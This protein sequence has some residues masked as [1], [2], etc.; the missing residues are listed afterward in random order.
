MPKYAFQDSF[1]FAP[2]AFLDRADY[3]PTNLDGT[4]GTGTW[5]CPSGYGSFVITPAHRARVNETGNAR[6]AFASGV[7]ISTE[8]GVK[9]RV[10][11][12]S[13]PADNN[14][15]FHLISHWDGTYDGA[16]SFVGACYLFGI[17][18]GSGSDVVAVALGFK[19]GLVGD[20]F[21]SLAVPGA[22]VGDAFDLEI[23]T[24]KAG[25][26]LAVNCYL[27]RGI[28]GQYLVSSGGTPAYQANRAILFSWTEA[29]T[30]QLA[31]GRG[32]VRVNSIADDASGLHF[33]DFAIPNYAGPATAIE[34]SG[35]AGGTVGVPSDPIKLQPDGT[36]SG[37]YTL[38][39][40]GK[41]GTWAPAP[42]VVF[43]GTDAP[44]QVTYAAAAPGSC[45][46][47]LAGGSLA[48]VPAT[49]PFTAAVGPHAIKARVYPS[50]NVLV[51]DYADAAGNPTNVASAT[52]GVG[53]LTITRGGKPTVYSLV[54]PLVPAYTTYPWLAFVLRPTITTA[55]VD[56]SGASYASVGGIAGSFATAGGGWA[57]INH[58][59]T[60]TFPDG[61]SVGRSSGYVA[62][63]DQYRVTSDPTGTGTWTI[64]GLP[65]GPYVA[66]AS[67]KM[68]RDPIN[69]RRARYTCRDHA[70]ATLAVFD[71]IDQTADLPGDQVMWGAILATKLGTVDV[72]GGTLAVTVDNAAGAGQ[73][74]ADGLYVELRP[75]AMR[76]GDTAVLDMPARA[77]VTAAGP[78]SAA[79][80]L[81]VPLADDAEALPFDPAAPRLCKQGYDKYRPNYSDIPA[82]TSYF[83]ADLIKT[84][85][86]LEILEGSGTVDAAGHLTALSPG[87]LARAW[88]PN[89]SENGV[90]SY[91]TTIN[92]P[93]P[94][95]YRIVYD[96]TLGR[97]ANLSLG[98]YR[99]NNAVGIGIVDRG[100]AVVGKTR[101]RTMTIAD[102]PYQ[103]RSTATSK[104]HYKRSYPLTLYL[105]DAVTGLKLFD[106]E[107]PPDWPYM[108]HPVAMRRF[109]G[110]D[111]GAIRM[112]DVNQ[113]Q[114][115]VDY[116]D[117]G[118]PAQFSVSSL[119]P[120][121]FAKVVA[122][123]PYLPGEEDFFPNTSYF[124]A[125]RVVLD[126]PF[127]IKDGQSPTFSGNVPAD[128]YLSSTRGP[129][130]N[131]GFFNVANHGQYARPTSDPNVILMQMSWVDG[132]TG[133]T[134][135][136]GPVANLAA[137]VDVSSKG[138][139][140]SFA[141]PRGS[142]PFRDQVT[143]CVETGVPLWSNLPDHGTDACLTRMATVNRDATAPGTP[144]YVEVGNEP[145]NTY[146]GSY[147]WNIVARHRMA[148]AHA[149]DPVAHP[150]NPQTWME[151]L[152]ARSIHAVD[153]IRA[154]YAADPRGDRSKDV[155][156]VINSNAG[157]GG[158]LRQACDWFFAK[159]AR[160]GMVAFANYQEF[161]RSWW[162]NP[163]TDAKAA[164]DC[165]DL[166]AAADVLA[167]C[168]VRGG[169]T[170]V[171]RGHAALLDDPKY[172]GHFAGIPLGNY[173]GGLDTLTWTNLYNPILYS[174][175]LHRHPRM[176]PLTLAWIQAQEAAAHATGHDLKIMCKYVADY[177]DSLGFPA[178]WCVFMD[179]ASLAGTG[180]AA[181][182][183]NLW[184]FGRPIYSPEAGAKRAYAAPGVIP[185]PTPTPTATPTPT[186]TPTAT[187]TPT[188]TPPPAPPPLT[189]PALTTA[190]LAQVAQVAWEA[191]VARLP[192][193]GRPGQ[194]T[195]ICPI[196]ALYA[197]DGKGKWAPAGSVVS[198]YGPDG[199]GGWTW[200]SSA[201]HPAQ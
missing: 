156:G 87:G 99:D 33:D 82:Q 106:G 94:A 189:P 36:H 194:P 96:D 37:T 151:A 162:A 95:T 90:D 35:P 32:G 44:R 50:G 140:L 125:V 73:L 60:P 14:K 191:A 170:G 31:K 112:L 40:G 104:R 123:D 161:D 23:I 144:W 15:Y 49:L 54:N 97:D 91:G 51:I 153:L 89:N 130:G 167:L 55:N 118:D 57:E 30:A 63:N 198:I 66:C 192:A 74:V 24:A 20:H 12:A 105:G 149:K 139:T 70:G 58:A 132:G 129:T 134:D 121:L 98:D 34:W 173:E 166:D 142:V 148:A 164:L 183:G 135:Y 47:T 117:F 175:A 137:H 21:Q 3:V 154:V 127:P 152:A 8:Y 46:L 29:G 180:D 88:M 155:V 103:P 71:N 146:Q 42:T 81:A 177:S 165:C 68:L 107:T 61:A 9:A 184:D 124:G 145:W 136:A 79:H 26:D 158:P 163:D 108:T 114:D 172:G 48:P 18:G 64:T 62:A 159:G 7:P 119:K 197:D 19:P 157:D 5:A 187:P 141:Q 174:H 111:F 6:W 85:P 147:L 100:T 78:A 10:T 102:P 11:L 143:F 86:A 2:G 115:V 169:F 72:T 150:D 178:N 176:F 190:D 38:D 122:L 76:P 22:A 83:Y 182:E 120:T 201:V 27:Q 131:Q 171:I 25:A 195:W 1:G 179:R 199:H 16:T 92:Q 39:D 65:D 53:T 126:R 41:G 13:I 185:T 45:A 160:F 80:A 168:S 28:D 186:P 75:V 109:S 188:P 113:D 196:V 43:D 181:A 69:T 138:I 200:H 67:L 193:S 17:Q 84:L 116:E 56:D 93:S 77:V 52:G 133:G 128:A 59:N 110:H 4:P 101:V